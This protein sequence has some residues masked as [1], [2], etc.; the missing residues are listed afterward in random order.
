MAEITRPQDAIKAY[1]L[2]CV[3][4]ERVEVELCPAVN[5]ALYAFRKGDNPYRKKRTVSVEHMKNMREA[6]SQL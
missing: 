3:G 6:K 1:C 2:D 5:C 4:G